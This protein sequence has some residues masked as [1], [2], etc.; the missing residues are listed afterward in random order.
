[1]SDH[2]LKINVSTIAGAVV[3]APQGDVDLNASPMLKVELKR[4]AAAVPPPSRLIV[5]LSGVSYM[6]SSGLATLV[7]ALQAA[8][9]GQHKLIVCGLQPRV[10]AIFD[11][12]KLAMV[13]SITST[14]EQALSA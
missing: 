4:S 2:A 6:D 11:I 5:D 1:M 7:E 3:I 14:V 8:R 9:K 13:F 12:A 10:R